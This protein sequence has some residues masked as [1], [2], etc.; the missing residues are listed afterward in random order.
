MREVYPDVTVGPLFLPRTATDARFFRAAGIPAYGFSPFAI[1]VTD[2][3]IVGGGNE[4]ISLP[5][6]VEGVAIYRRLVERLT[7]RP[8]LGGTESAAGK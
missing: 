8:A 2:T 3:L 7:A 6:Y 4:R 5:G 1:P